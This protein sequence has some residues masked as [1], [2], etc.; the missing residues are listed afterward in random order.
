MNLPKQ[1]SVMFINYQLL[2]TLPTQNKMSALI[3]NKNNINDIMDM[4]S[5]YYP[6]V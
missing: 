1:Y 2:M 3:K 5:K 6:S 4:A